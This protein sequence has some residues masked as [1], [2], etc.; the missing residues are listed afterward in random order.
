L[1]TTDGRFFALTS[2][3]Q[4]IAAVQPQIHGMRPAGYARSE[5]L[6][7]DVIILNSTSGL[8]RG[9]FSR[10]RSD[11]VEIGRLTVT[12]LVPEGARRSSVLAVHSP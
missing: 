9:M 7:S 5:I 1:L 4:I 2:D 6:G 12:Y 8:Y 10:H 3:E 11:G